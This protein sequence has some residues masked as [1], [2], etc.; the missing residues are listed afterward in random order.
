MN[1]AV[2]ELL[3]ATAGGVPPPT[4]LTAPDYA[5]Y[6]DS[7]A[8]GSGAPASGDKW[9]NVLADMMQSYAGNRPAVYPYGIGGSRLGTHAQLQGG[10]K[11]LVTVTGGQIPTSGAVTLT[12]QDP[13]FDLAESPTGTAAIPDFTLAGVVGTIRRPGGRHADPITF[14][15]NVTGA[16]VPTSGWQTLTFNP[17][18]ANRAKA[19]LYFGPHNSRSEALGIYQD[20]RLGTPYVIDT[21]TAMKNYNQDPLQRWAILGLSS[22]P[23]VTERVGGNPAGAYDPE[24]TEIF[25]TTGYG[26]A[27]GDIRAMAGAAHWIDIRAG[28][29]NTTSNPAVSAYAYNG[30]TPNATDLD[31]TGAGKRYPGVS[32]RAVGDSV[33]HLNA[34]GQAWIAHKVFTHCQTYAWFTP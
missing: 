27:T 28:L 15:R 29:I 31:Q 7:M 20:H 16:A 21:L 2:A 11:M 23:T 13:E 6:G 12:P 3:T 26:G 19:M 24:Y 33:G 10:K 8:G 5:V 25:G 32:L 30:I 22:G 17:G 9:F 34:A 18:E 1:L 4:G 14:T